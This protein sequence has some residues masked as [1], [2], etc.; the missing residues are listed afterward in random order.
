MDVFDR[1]RLGQGQEIIVALQKAVAGMKTIAAEVLF[2]QVQALD[3]GAHRPVN[4]QD[5]LARGAFQRRQCVLAARGVRVGGWI[6]GPIHLHKLK[7][8][9]TDIII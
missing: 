5:A 1:L 2:I 6:G 4:E 3:L 7:P 9:H 8:L